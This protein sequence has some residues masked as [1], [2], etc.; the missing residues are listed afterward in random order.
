MGAYWASFARDGVPSCP[1]APQWP[2]FKMSGGSFLRFD[3]DSDGGIEV[4]HSADNL[5]AL[6]AYIVA[7]PN[8]DDARRCFVVQKMGKWMFGMRIKKHLETV[9]GC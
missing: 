3:A 1:G 9:I 4:L 2:V 5:D 7:D 8:L 6:V